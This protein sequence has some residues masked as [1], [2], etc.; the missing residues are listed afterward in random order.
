MVMGELGVRLPLYRARKQA[1]ATAQAQLDLQAAE[2]D[3]R[4][5]EARTRAEIGEAMARIERASSLIRLYGDPI[6]PQAR[7]AFDS[8]SAAYGAG[9]VPFSTVIEDFL[10]VLKGQIEI[11]TQHADRAKSIASLELLV[12]EDLVLPGGGAPGTLLQGEHHE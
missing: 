5:R 6:V 4:G 9:K 11:V 12:G 2:N 1:Q 7:G 10:A 8:A 3:L